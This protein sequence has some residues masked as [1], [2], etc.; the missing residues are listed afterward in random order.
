MERKFQ[1]FDIERV[2]VE[3][4]FRTLLFAGFRVF[5]VFRGSSVFVS[6]PCGFVPLR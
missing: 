3:I 6:R 1:F 2:Y 4:T 5:L